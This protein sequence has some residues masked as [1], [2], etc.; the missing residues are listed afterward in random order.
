MEKGKEK[1]VWEDNQY[2]YNKDLKKFK[3]FQ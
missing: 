2:S 3:H 1:I